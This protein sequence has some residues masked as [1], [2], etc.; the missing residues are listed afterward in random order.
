[1]GGPTFLHYSLLTA[2][3]SDPKA[4]EIHTACQ[5]LAYFSGNMGEGG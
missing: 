4:A 1:M 3:S 2:S 5:S